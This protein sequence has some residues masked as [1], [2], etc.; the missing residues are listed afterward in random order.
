MPLWV[1]LWYMAPL[2]DRFA[3][4][5]M[6]WHGAWYVYAGPAQPDL[7]PDPGEGPDG[8]GPDGGV[9]ERRRPSGPLPVADVRAKSSAEVKMPGIEVE[10]PKDVTLDF[11]TR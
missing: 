2:I 8:E 10:R 4:E 3:Y 5:W 7:P 6:W 1:R 9:R 11:K